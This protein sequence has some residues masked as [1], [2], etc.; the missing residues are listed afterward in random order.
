VK[1]NEIHLE[2]FR[3]HADTS[4]TKLRKVNV[5]LGKNGVG[6][7]TIIDSIAYGLVGI[8]RGMSLNGAGAELLVGR[9]AGSKS[10]LV[11]LGNG[12]GTIKRG[13]G[14]G[15]KSR[16]QA[17]LEGRFN[18][19]PGILRTLLN[20]T[21]FLSLKPGE[22]RNLLLSV[23]QKP[24]SAEEITEII[25]DDISYIEEADLGNLEGVNEAEKRLRE[26]RPELKR[27][28]SAIVIPEIPERDRDPAVAIK[29]A[30]DYLLGIREQRDKVVRQAGAYLAKQQQA[31][32]LKDS[33]EAALGHIAEAER[34]GD[35]EQ[36]K[37]QLKQRAAKLEDLEAA[38]KDNA[39]KIMKLRADTDSLDREL[40]EKKGRFDKLANV[41]GDCPTCQ[42][43]VPP[44]E[45]KEV[46]A[47]LKKEGQA[48]MKRISKSKKTLEKLSPDMLINQEREDLERQIASL[49]VALSDLKGIK[50]RRDEAEKNL[51]EAEK[52]LS[53]K[54][55]SNSVAKFDQEISEG[56]EFIRGQR[57]LLD[58]ESR[59]VT[60]RGERQ[61][62]EKRL[63][64][65]ERLIDKIGPKGILRKK[66]MSDGVGAMMGQVGEITKAIGLA[67]FGIDL[68]KTTRFIVNGLPAVMLS[69][70]EQYRLSLALAAVLAKRSG[71]GILCLDGAEVLDIENRMAV[72]GVLEAAGLE[73]AFI[74]AT[75]ETIPAGLKSDETWAFYIVGKEN[76]VS[77]VRRV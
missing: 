6:K 19:E 46:M 39:A 54:E 71:A 3:S 30:E 75:P 34:Q 67:G 10:F 5:F 74:A 44:A 38:E 2:N 58:Q 27:Q 50:G 32:A 17:K 29:E 53:E 15:P 45:R 16:L 76:G 56:E 55:G 59:A 42:R 43:P 61:K 23:T 47:T 33:A 12:S 64:A 37:L 57:N 25:G 51:A 66:M 22:Q 28:I 62:L 26:A 7:S 63:A 72:T 40:A 20:P 8:C 9:K 11:T 70:S 31:R 69:T 48:L 18:L 1:I 73:Q 24:L 68:G 14:D 77:Q 36:I 13:L 52:V 41:K 21:S 35:P 49:N 65:Y 4:I 60:L